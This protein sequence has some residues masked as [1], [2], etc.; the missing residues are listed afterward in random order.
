MKARLFFLLISVFATADVRAQDVDLSFLT[1]RAEA[2]EYEETTRYDEVMA[3]L[4]VLAAT[5]ERMHLTHFGYSVEGRRLPL[6]VYGDVADATPEAVQAT[7]KTRVFVQ[8][9]IH[10][11]EV[12]GK[13]AA[14]V[15]LRAL[16]AGR[17]AAWADSLV[18]LVAPIYNAD[19]NE[20]VSLYHRPQQHG[21]VGGMGQRPNAQGY[22]L[23][24]DHMKLDTPEARSLVRLFSLY[25]PHV[26]IDL[27]TTNGTVHAY[28]LTYAPPLHPSTPASIVRLL[29]EAWLPDVT[30]AIDTSHGWA[31]T[32]YGNVPP[33]GMDVPRGW[34]TFDHRPRFGNNYVGLRGRFALLS[35]AYAY[36]TFEERTLASL[37]FIEEAIAYAARN[38][39]TIRQITATADSTPIVGTPLALRAEHA[40]SDKLEAILLGEVERERHPYTGREILRRLDVR[41]PDTMYTY[42]TFR[43][44]ET[45][46]APRAYIIPPDL[47]VARDRIM[48][49]GIRYEVL[50]AA[51]ARTVERFHID[52]VQ[53]SDEPFQE[54]LEQTLFGTY[55]TAEENLPA[56]TWLVP[57]DQPLGRLAFALLEPRSD[58][59]LASWGL[60][61]DALKK[62]AFYPIWRLPAVKDASGTTP[63]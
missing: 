20:Q 26:V 39:D 61:S 22:D 12:A 49:H 10:A 11:G 52:S 48:A 3:F 38:A 25:D 36:A 14:L 51:E 58:D 55:V 41:R 30:A 57:T 18:L 35:E 19:G 2:T 4:D 56:G 46:V 15:L 24:R 13:E 6:M 23:N 42:G 16:A 27:H 5:S 1:T 45:A 60:L 29:R 21:P 37:Y 50:E 9:N 17:H 47:D 31:T 34:Y 33:E 44:T 53:T 62:G 7:G 59:G 54:H 28:H 63:R 8:A 40:R 43:P 32:Y